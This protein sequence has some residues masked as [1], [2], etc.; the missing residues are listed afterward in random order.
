MRALGAW[1]QAAF[2]LIH[3]RLRAPFLDLVLPTLTDTWTWIVPIAAL[4]LYTFA[5]G[6]K[7]GSLLLCSGMVVFLVA[8]GCATGLKSVFLR[9]RPYQSLADMAML[10]ERAASS[11]FPSNHAANAFALATLFGSFY[12]KLAIPFIA[13]AAV[14]GYSRIYLGDHYPLDVVA[15]ALL[16]TVL[17][18]AAGKASEW[19]GQ[20][21]KTPGP[22]PEGQGRPQ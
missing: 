10:L 1:D 14:V 18:L 5:K 4:V 20:R 3:T 19:L 16:G 9:P 21:G 8:D 17:G 22:R 11:S 13:I 7:R 6:G 15:G 12:R 2:S